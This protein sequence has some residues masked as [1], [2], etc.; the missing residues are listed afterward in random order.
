[1][2][3]PG[4]ISPNVP[5]SQL[6]AGQVTSQLFTQLHF[7]YKMPITIGLIIFNLLFQA[8]RQDLMVTLVTFAQ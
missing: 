2:L 3:P 6:A 5:L 1:M 4:L 7:K 8:L